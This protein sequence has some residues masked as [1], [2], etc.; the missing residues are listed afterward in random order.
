MDFLR[1]A[2]KSICLISSLLVLSCTDR[3]MT[4]GDVDTGPSE[5]AKVDTIVVAHWNIGHFS[6]GKASSTRITE[7]D[8]PKM[9]K[10]YK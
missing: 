9:I 8:S 2:L 5:E 3:L 10:E 6:L 4:N 1:R 7:K